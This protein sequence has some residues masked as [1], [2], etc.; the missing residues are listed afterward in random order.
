MRLSFLTML[1]S[2][3]FAFQVNAESVAKEYDS[4]GRYIGDIVTN[5]NRST[6]HNRNGATTGYS[7]EEHDQIKHYNSNGAT[8][9]VT[10][11]H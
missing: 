1:I 5:G 7:V 4:T 6:Y 2:C 10:K 11:L 9:G 8:V 3:S